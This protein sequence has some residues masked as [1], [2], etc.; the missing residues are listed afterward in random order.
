MPT[1]K[2]LMGP[3]INQEWPV[4]LPTVL[5]GRD[6]VNCA[7]VLSGVSVSRRHAAI[8]REGDTYWVMDLA[9]RGGTRLNGEL[10]EK[11]QPHRLRGN[12]LIQ[13]RDYVLAFVDEDSES[14]AGGSVTHWIRE[15]KEGEDDR[16]QKELSARYYARLVALA[17]SKLAGVPR[18]A[19]DEEDVV[20]CALNS[21]FAGA[22][23]GKFTLL[24]DRHDLWRLLTKITRRK[25]INQR[26]KACAQ[27]RGSGKVLHESCFSRPG[28]EEA[29]DGLAGLANNEPTP[30]LLAE[31]SEQL[32]RLMERL[33]EDLRDVAVFKLEGYTNQEIAAKIGKVERTVERK[34]TQIRGIWSDELCSPE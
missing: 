29:G 32:R 22:D 23:Q 4:D 10:L 21:F 30:D 18:S 24:S 26:N 7:V 27:K 3:A 6:S 19:E 17:R 9:S 31:I 16:A 15:L 13:I 14:D 11:K 2:L 8:L 12:D 33:P 25:A 28:R 5:I 1:L 20:L 34:L